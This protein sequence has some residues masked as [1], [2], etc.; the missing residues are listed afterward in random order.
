M[1]NELIDEEQVEKESK[2][3]NEYL[4]SVLN[5]IAFTVGLT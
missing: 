3:H 1:N 4:N 5:I 2:I